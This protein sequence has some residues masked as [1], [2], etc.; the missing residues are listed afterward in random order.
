MKIT[1]GIITGGG[2]ETDVLQ[3]IDALNIPSENY[4]IIVVGGPHIEWKNL[5]HIPFSERPKKM[6]ITKKKQVICESACFDNVVLTHDYMLFDPGWYEGWVK[7]GDDWD[8]AMNRIY[9]GDGQR[10][11]DWL[12]QEPHALIPYDIDGYM[13]TMYISGS[14]WLAKKQ[15]MLQHS[16]DLN[17]GWCEAEDLEWSG[18][19]RGF[20]RYKMNPY[21]SV[22]SKKVK[23]TW[24]ILEENG[25]QVWVHYKHFQSILNALGVSVTDEDGEMMPRDDRMVRSIHYLDFN[26][27][28]DDVR[29]L[30]PKNIVVVGDPFGLTPFAANWGS[31]QYG[32]ANVTVVDYIEGWGIRISKTMHTQFQWQADH[33]VISQPEELAT[34]TD[35]PIDM[36]VLGG[37]Y[38]AEKKLRELLAAKPKFAPKCAV[39]VYNAIS[40]DLKKALPGGA[41]FHCFYRAGVSK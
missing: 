26:G 27:F 21:S 12:A 2:L 37:T 40:D 23:E 10:F 5:C 19:C 15:F 30:K 41:S 8:V 14:Y 7:F 17:R 13:P 16:L 22:R 24:Q 29:R 4:E 28:R 33:K 32:G 11:R 1:F 20:W 34:V 36:L 25:V 6:W 39:F 3:S 18:R 31:R 35:Q 9:N 38:E